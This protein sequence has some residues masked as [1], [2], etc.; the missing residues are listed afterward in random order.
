ML[1][2]SFRVTK[3]DKIFYNKCSPYFIS[4]KARL[5]RLQL[6][7][8]TA[9][10]CCIYLGKREKI[11]WICWRISGQRCP[12]LWLNIHS[13]HTEE[14]C[15]QDTCSRLRPKEKDS[16]WQLDILSP[17]VIAFPICPSLLSNITDAFPENQNKTKLTVSRISRDYDDWSRGRAHTVISCDVDLVQTLIKDYFCAIGWSRNGE[18]LRNG[19][20]V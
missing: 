20:S 6:S 13:P 16:V 18:E 4:Y 17:R 7:V 15:P 19:W 10:W 11:L 3:T 14:G 9:Y 2:G 8:E 1:M 5:E 12:G